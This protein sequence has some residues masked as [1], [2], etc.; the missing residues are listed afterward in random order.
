LISGYYGCA[1]IGPEFAFNIRALYFE[2][3]EKDEDIDL[4]LK[5]GWI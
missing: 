3:Q 2:S 4:Q 5:E 1:I